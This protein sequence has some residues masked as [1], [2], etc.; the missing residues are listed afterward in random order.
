[1]TDDVWIAGGN[2]T[3]RWDG[4]RWRRYDLNV[5][6]KRKGQPIEVAHFHGTGHNA[7]D[8]HDHGDCSEL[9]GK[10]GRTGARRVGKERL[11]R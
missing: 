11:L 8:K 10:E 7:D 9:A 6:D 4:H 2:Q 5:V 3:V 1:V